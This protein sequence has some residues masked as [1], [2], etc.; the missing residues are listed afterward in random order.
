MPEK[1]ELA[2]W[3]VDYL[4][5]KDAITKQITAIK[6]NQ[7]TADVIIEGSLKNQFI[8]IQPEL[9]DFKKLDPL[10]DKHIVLVTKNT[11]ANMEFL[12]KNWNEF[13]KYLHMSVYF[14]NPNSSTDKRWTIFPAT[15]NKI[16][17]KNSLKKGIESLYATVE[18]C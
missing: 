14:I 4:K 6:Q 9:A 2:A 15:H 12:I 11:K 5:S 3:I 10:K 1:E 17:E 13:I 8:I 7:P 16:I 18:P